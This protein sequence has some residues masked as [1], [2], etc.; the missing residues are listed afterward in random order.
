MEDW[1]PLLQALIWPAFLGVLIVVFW[2]KVREIASAVARR[3]DAGAEMSFGPSGLSVGK[4]PVLSSASSETELETAEAKSP[5]SSLAQQ[6]YLVHEARFAR[7]A[8][9]K[10]DFEISVRV[11]TDTQQLEDRIERVEYVLHPSYHRRVRVAE[12]RESS[13]EL[14]FLA[15][16]QFNLRANVFLRGEKEPLVL[17]RFV[18]F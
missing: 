1:I 2:S 3:I 16:G 18:D 14:K 6:F 15:W 8:Q 17:W 4:A 12:Q 9:G 11:Y 7:T 5:A 13:F 10:R